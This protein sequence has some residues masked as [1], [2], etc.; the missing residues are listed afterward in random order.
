VDSSVG[1]D[2]VTAS[3]LR[4]VREWSARTGTRAHARA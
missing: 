3:L 4:A 1:P 2:E